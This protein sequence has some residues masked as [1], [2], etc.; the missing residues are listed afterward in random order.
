[1]AGGIIY[2]DL[3]VR[4]WMNVLKS[5]NYADADKSNNLLV[6]ASL[7]SLTTQLRQNQTEQEQVKQELQSMFAVGIAFK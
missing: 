5:E 1:M 4:C 6:S 7:H 3:F 2:R